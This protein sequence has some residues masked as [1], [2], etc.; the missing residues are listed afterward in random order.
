MTPK[1]LK[2]KAKDFVKVGAVSFSFFM[3]KKKQK[4]TTFS[5]E[6]SFFSFSFTIVFLPTDVSLW[7]VRSLRSQ[8]VRRL[9]QAVLDHDKNISEHLNDL[10]MKTIKHNTFLQRDKKF[11]E[12]AKE[13][14]HVLLPLCRILLRL[15]EVLA[16]MTKGEFCSSVSFF[17]V[18]V[19]LLIALRK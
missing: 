7:I 13:E 6:E 17:P 2:D 9:A 11:G 1:F 10:V 18:S 8:P 14:F 19:C 4:H 12:V 15:E 3:A 16:R 5:S